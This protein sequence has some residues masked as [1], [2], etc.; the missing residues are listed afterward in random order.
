METSSTLRLITLCTCGACDG[1]GCPITGIVRQIIIYLFHFADDVN[2]Q[3]EEKKNN[4]QLN[5]RV[6]VERRFQS[7]FW[8]NFTDS[9]II[10]LKSG[11]VV[12]SG[13]GI[14]FLMAKAVTL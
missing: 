1:H 5:L 8:Q 14:Q 7:Q 6:L 12:N 2:S 3:F 13:P 4:A 10:F 9:F 11:Y